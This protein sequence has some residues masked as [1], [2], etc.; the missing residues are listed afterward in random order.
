MRKIKKL[1]PFAFFLKSSLLTNKKCKNKY[2]NFLIFRQVP[3]L[4][5]KIFK[6]REQWCDMACH[7]SEKG[8]TVRCG[9][10]SVA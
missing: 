5:K 10:P 9:V 6:L 1:F 4:N 2:K 8:C 3:P 7:K